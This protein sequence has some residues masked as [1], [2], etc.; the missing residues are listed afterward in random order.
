MENDNSRAWIISLI[1]YLHNNSSICT[2]LD[3]LHISSF[4]I[5]EFFIPV[6]DLLNPDLRAWC[7]WIMTEWL[8]FMEY[9]ETQW[10]LPIRHAITVGL[11]SLDIVVALRLFIFIMILLL[12]R[13]S[14]INFIMV[15]NF[16]VEETRD[17]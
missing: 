8:Q 15:F 14:A 13:C 11:I 10:T 1:P 4:G 3:C 7:G 17:V 5:T 12:K 2:C 16:I 9:F 6:I